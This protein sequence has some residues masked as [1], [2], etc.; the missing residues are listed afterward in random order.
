MD[1]VGIDI[2]NDVFDEV[3]HLL[4]SA[5]KAGSRKLKHT[6]GAGYKPRRHKCHA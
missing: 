5:G 3:F 4:G 2:S 6:E 1:Q